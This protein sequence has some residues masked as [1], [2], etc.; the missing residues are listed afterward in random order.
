MKR[1]TPP[2]L[3]LS[4]AEQRWLDAFRKMDQ[5]CA[6]SNL[7]AM[8]HMAKVFPRHAVPTLRLVAGG[9]K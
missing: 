9:A 1:V 6:A 8:E 3:P 4:Q 5:Q 7:R 2:A